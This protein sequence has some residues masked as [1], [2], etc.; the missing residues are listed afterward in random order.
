MVKHSPLTLAFLD[1]KPAAAGRE[2][3]TMAVDEAAV[4]LDA[5]PTRFAAPALAAMGPWS[6]ASVASKMSPVSAAAS[7]RA[8]DYRDASAILRIIPRS[9]RARILGELPE[10]LQRDLETSLT[11]PDD[12]VGAHMTT[13]ILTLTEQHNVADAIELMRKPKKSKAD[14][15]FIVDGERKFAGAVAAS[16]LLRHPRETPL[17][18]IMDRGVIPISARATLASCGDLSSWNTCMV[19]PVLSR[20][21]LVIG[22]LPRKAVTHTENR[23]RPSAVEPIRSI[24]LSILDAYLVSVFGL[25]RLMAGGE[26]FLST[27][28][29]RRP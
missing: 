6:A 17:G 11:F 20:Q 3:A 21:K 4:F 13:A 10:K 26:Q 19:L 27:L 7:L 9:D 15:V 29:E 23:K 18:E 2:L 16:D 1:Q 5:V 14:I 22:A 12:T 28:K 8:I 25:V 24:P